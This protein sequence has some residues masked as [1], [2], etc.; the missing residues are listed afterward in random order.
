MKNF[1]SWLGLRPDLLVADLKK[2]AGQ[3]SD[4]GFNNDSMHGLMGIL[5][6]AAYL[7]LPILMLTGVIG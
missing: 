1:V 6:L 2:A 4:D 5:A 7:I 3:L